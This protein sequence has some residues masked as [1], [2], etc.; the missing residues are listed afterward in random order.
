MNA[1]PFCFFLTLIAVLFVSQLYSQES[2]NP[3]D[4]KTT[5]LAEELNK[6]VSA[7]G[8]QEAKLRV[9]LVEKLDEVKKN[10]DANKKKPADARI[11][12]SDKLQTL[13]DEFLATGKLPEIPELRSSLQNYT[14]GMDEARRDCLKAYERAI[15]GYDKIGDRESAKRV[16]EEKDRFK[17]SQKP[18]DSLQSGSMWI[19]EFTRIEAGSRELGRQRANMQVLSRDKSDFSARLEIQGEG[20]AHHIREFKGKIINGT[21]SWFAKDVTVIKGHEGHN[22]SGKIEGDRIALRYGGLTNIGGKPVNGTITL[23]RKTNK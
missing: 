14:R 8:G 6:A 23:D 15:D 4:G 5:G 7:Y 20:V 2:S 21:I 19:G 22:H 10:I 17:E 18:T 12:A 11:A 3:A 16:I 9:Q 1:K 13:R